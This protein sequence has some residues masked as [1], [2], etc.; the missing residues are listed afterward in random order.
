ME[1]E[2]ESESSNSE[3]CSKSDSGIITPLALTFHSAVERGWKEVRTAGTAE[4][5]VPMAELMV[6]TAELRPKVLLVQKIN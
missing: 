5:M 3:K 6:L 2:S 1:L 4:L